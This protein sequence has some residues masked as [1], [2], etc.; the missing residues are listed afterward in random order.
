VWEQAVLPAAARRATLVYCPANLGPVVSRRNV[1]VIHDVASL[2]QPE[3]YSPAYAAYQRRLLPLLARRARRM[4][5]VS[6][7]SR[8]ELGDVLGV[9]PAKVAVVPNGVDGGVF[10]PDVDAAAARAVYGLTRP[11]ALVVGTRIARKNGAALGA[12][13]ERLGE[14]GIELVQAGSGR[15]YMQPGAEPPARQLGYVDE[16]L[17]PGLY[18]GAELLLMPSL[19]EGFGLPCIEAM[20]CGTPVVASDRGALPETCGD[21]ALLVDPEDGAAVADAAAIA[22]SDA[23]RREELVEAGRRRAAELTWDAA[24]RRTD[25][26]IDALLEPGHA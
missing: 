17:L 8:R 1:L 11:Y 3:W 4:I 20:A 21:A 2:R 6:E 22:V 18:A 13:R 9:D 14:L 10:S 24:A 12:A 5:T 7:F 26:V 15:S 23:V 16:S 19:Y 25:A